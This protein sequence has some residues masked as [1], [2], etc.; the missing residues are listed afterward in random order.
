MFVEA[1]D[2]L[3]PFLGG[4]ALGAAVMVLFGGL[5]VMSA[6]LETRPQPLTWVKDFSFLIVAGIGLG[7]SLVFG[8][9][10]TV[11]GKAVR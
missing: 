11:L 8:V 7:V 5:A 4:A 6:V 3:A 9:I 2:S 10:G 1:P